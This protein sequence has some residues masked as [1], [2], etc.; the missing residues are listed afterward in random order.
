MSF[1]GPDGTGVYSDAF[2]DRIQQMHRNS[3]VGEAR[4]LGTVI[5]HEIG[6]LLLGPHA[7][8]LAGIMCA[9]WHKEELRLI[10]IGCM[11]FTPDQSV[12]MRARI[13]PP[14]SRD[15]TLS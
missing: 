14:K 4:L 13:A 10:G 8:S 15:S 5:A 11:G 7:H 9:H 6:H 1:L 2:Y 12:R 3:G